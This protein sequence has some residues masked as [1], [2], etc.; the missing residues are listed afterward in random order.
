MYF[1]LGLGT[2]RG[3]AA[4]HRIL[5]VTER[6]PVVSVSA[7]MQVTGFGTI[8]VSPRSDADEGD[9]Y[10]DHAGHTDHTDHATPL[11]AYPLGDR[12]VP[13]LLARPRGDGG[14]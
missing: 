5:G 9:C 8:G 11:P 7:Q 1:T 3:P 12:T 4:G 13:R 2:A 10:D 6:T 14:R